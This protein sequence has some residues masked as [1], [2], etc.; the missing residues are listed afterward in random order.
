MKKLICAIV[1]FISTFICAQST[2]ALIGGGVVFADSLKSY[3]TTYASDS[4]YIVKLNLL[5]GFVS[6]THKDT[7]TAAAVGGIVD[8]LKAYKG[9]IRYTNGYAHVPVDTLWGTKALPLKNNAWNVDTVMAGGSGQTCTYVL[10]ENNIQL[11][12]IVNVNSGGE[13]RQG[14]NTPIVIEAMKKEN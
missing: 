10:L 1:L 8:S 11:L 14:R 7:G 3:S 13:I 4:S 2:G 9:M 5:Y 6:I 12:K